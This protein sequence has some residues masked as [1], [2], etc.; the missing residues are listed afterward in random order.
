MKLNA[1]FTSNM[2]FAANKPIRI[3]GEGNGTA[4]IGFAGR[5]IKVN[6]ENEGWMVEFPPM[7]YGGPYEL[8]F[9]HGGETDVLDDIYVG[10]VFLFAGQSN[11]Q[12][13][14]KD[15]GVP[16]ETLES[17]SL[18][19]TYGTDKIEKN[20]RF[21][22]KEGW[23]KC[24]QEEA[25]DWSAIGYFTALELVKRKNIAIGVINCFQGASVIESWVPERAFE[26]IGISIAPED[27]YY[28]HT[29]PEFASWNGDGTLY[30]YAFSQVV[31]LS[32]S[33]V[34]W[35]QGESDT[36]IAEALVYKQE[37]AELIR[38]WRNDL[39]NDQL[40]FVVVQIHDF[41]NRDDEGWHTLQQ[42]QLEV[43]NEVD[44]VKTVIS[45]DICETDVIHPTTKDILS[46]RIAD[47][48]M[49]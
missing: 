42:A 46:K 32:L 3:F 14:I 26:K 44:N 29:T 49:P 22:P 13:K 18:M 5:E 27:K 40:P 7:E 45:R 11:M 33:G 1:I 20:E 10:E 16:T 6:S 36:S 35:Y 43:E 15:T 2:V 23:A 39:M 12:L 25:P 47:A 9:E 21:T 38:I 4:T 8:R 34:I 19:R 48:L 24:K 41:D 31:P 28:D 30:G 17:N 37:L